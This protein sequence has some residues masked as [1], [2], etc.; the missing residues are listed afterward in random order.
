MTSAMEDEGGL[1]YGLEF[2]CRALCALEAD[3]ERVRFAVA[4][5]S[6]KAQNQ[7]HVLEMDEEART[8][9]KTVFGHATGEV[10]G[11]TASPT[12]ADLMISVHGALDASGTSRRQEAT[13]WSLSD[14][15]EEAVSGIRELKPHCTLLSGQTS[16]GSE[17]EENAVADVSHVSFSPGQTSRIMVLAGDRLVA[18]DVGSGGAASIVACR[19]IDGKGLSQLT[20]G[21]WNPHQGS[22]VFAAVADDHVVRAFDVRHFNSGQGGNSDG[23][24]WKVESPGHHTVRSLDF[25]PN[26]QYH[27]ATAGDDGCVRVW[28]LRSPATPLLARSDHSHWVWSVKFNQFHDQLVLTASS[29]SKVALTCLASISSEPYGPLVDEDEDERGQQN[30]PAPI[31]ADGLI[32]MYEDHEES[33][34]SCAWSSADPWTFASLSYDGRLVIN[35]VPRA[36]KFKILNLL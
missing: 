19:R 10:W 16:S 36:V 21:A 30:E 26:R 5:Q 3:T 24:V 7:L 4:T 6:L 27:L 20:T 28:D 1:I 18:Q 29:D 32:K 33:V 17:V 2:Q 9:K 35:Q 34:Y 31:L 23:P 12:D 11:L 13:L 14:Q 8:V 25:N 22:N 15:H